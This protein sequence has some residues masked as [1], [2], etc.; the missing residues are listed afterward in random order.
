MKLAIA[1]AFLGLAFLSSGC[2]TITKGSTDTV[3]VDTRPPGATCALSQA[4]V[5]VAYVN[6][7]PGTVQVEKSKNDIS[8]R[9]EREGF[10]PAV[11]V[12]SSELEGMTF[13]NILFGGLIG[14]AV[15]ASSGALNKYPPMVQIVMVPD[16]F[17]D[18][19]ERDRFFDD[20]LRDIDRAHEDAVASIRRSCGQNADECQSRLARAD[21]S[22]AEAVARIGAQRLAAVVGNG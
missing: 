1:T 6:P 12:L 16:Q 18:E 9:C 21:D 11:G 22:R 13:G 4:G 8:V 15:D 17:R 20:R 14:V 3:T 2:A 19:F 7:T 5:T 10:Q